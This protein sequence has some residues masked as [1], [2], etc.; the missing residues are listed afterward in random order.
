M[1]RPPNDCAAEVGAGAA[2]G[3]KNKKEAADKDTTRRDQLLAL[4]RYL[5]E[6]AAEH[7]RNADKTTGADHERHYGAWVDIRIA[8]ADVLTKLCNRR[9]A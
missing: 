2:R 8:V 9:A 3:S 5:R 4:L 6:K 7:R 1:T